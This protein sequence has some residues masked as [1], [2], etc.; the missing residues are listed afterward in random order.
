MREKGGVASL[1][2]L[3]AE[4][5]CQSLRLA[6]S[7]LMHGGISANAPLKEKRRPRAALIYLL[8][9][10]AYGLQFAKL[11]RGNVKA[12]PGN[13]KFSQLVTFGFTFHPER[14]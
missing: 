9:M 13:A 12:S 4:R 2:P 1:R 14:S 10:P 6:S 5:S 8:C 3:S 11:G 7:R